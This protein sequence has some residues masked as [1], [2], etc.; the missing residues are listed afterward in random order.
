[1]TSVST[2]KIAS[3]TIAFDP[4]LCDWN[5]RP[6]PTRRL[7]VDGATPSLVLSIFLDQV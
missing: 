6:V 2:V 5:P 7:L 3:A 4:A 1:V